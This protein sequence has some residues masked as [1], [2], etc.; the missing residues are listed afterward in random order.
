MSLPIKA[1]RAKSA[2]K[3]C[4]Q[5]YVLLST[6]GKV[7]CETYALPFEKEKLAPP[8]GE[9]S[10]EQTEGG[11]VSHETLPDKHIHV[12]NAQPVVEREVDAVADHTRGAAH[13][14]VNAPG[15]NE[16]SAQGLVL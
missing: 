4:R 3:T 7:S 6:D 15:R 16:Q 10:A 9:L 8:V 2:G 13:K 1:K 14:T 11:N 5:A 12:L